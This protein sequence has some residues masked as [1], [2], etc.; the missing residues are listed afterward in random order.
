MLK[1]L[2]IAIGILIIV[3]AS[4][5][6][7]FHSQFFRVHDYVHAARVVEMKRALQEGQF[8]VRWT[9]NFGYGFGMPLFEFY[10]PLPYYGGAVL[11]WLG[12]DTILILKILWF[13]S[14]LVT[15]VG[16]YKL[17]AKLFGRSGGLVTSAA[18]TLA[19]Y[20]AV[21]LFVRGALSEAWGIMALPWILYGLV[22]LIDDFFQKKKLHH[23]WLVTTFSL[24]V[25]MLSHNLTTLMFVPI[26]FLLALVYVFARWRMKT[27]SKL[28][29]QRLF[30]SLMGSYVLAVGLTAFY[31]IPALVENSS[32]QISSILSGYFHYSN[33]FLYIRQFFQPNWGYGGSQWGPQDGFSFF[34]GWGQ[35]G[36]AVIGYILVGWQLIDTLVKTKR[37]KLSAQLWYRLGL[38]V[39][40]GLILAGSLFLTL[41]RSQIIWDTLPLL[42]YIQFPWRWI[43]VGIIILGLLAGFSSTL[44]K[45]TIFRW[46]YVITLLGVLLLNA[47]YFHPE[48][49]L[50]NA[51]DLYYTDEQRIQS[52]MSGILPDYIPQQMEMN[53]LTALG[54]LPM[55]QKPAVWCDSTECPKAL[56]ILINRGHE[57]LARTDFGQPTLVQFRV[58]NFPGWIMEIDGETVSTCTAEGE[59][60]C[61]QVQPLGNLGVI[62]PTHQHLVS[63][64]FGETP[65][66]VI[67][68]GLSVLSWL[69]L[70]SLLVPVKAFHQRFKKGADD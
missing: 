58:A 45:S 37:L 10:A 33:H 49:Y 12:L 59:E 35:I 54:Q 28:S 44:F 40:L 8:P 50:G 60:S 11:S 46:S 70:L 52:Q 65:V 57:K 66:R 22:V 48:S 67:S 43:S 2:C 31:Q 64:H 32:T 69:L 19:P 13:S 41:L 30:I 16:A 53:Q 29:Y 26:S 18:T 1:N 61:L 42:N 7:L 55:D 25:L 14:S 51:N 63:V 23:G 4:S 17:G 24:V 47:Q 62:M 38:V 20:R 68:D 5:W 27:R 39:V 34:L 56:S 36:A 15:A 9:K 3:V 6:S 21:N